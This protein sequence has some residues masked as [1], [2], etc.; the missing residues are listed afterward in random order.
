MHSWH[1]LMRFDLV[2]AL[3]QQLMKQPWLN[4]VL[5]SQKILVQQMDHAKVHLP[6]HT[7]QLA[8]V[9]LQFDQ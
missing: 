9:V 3:D 1:H 5:I 7:F 2:G 6:S 8:Q 4:Q